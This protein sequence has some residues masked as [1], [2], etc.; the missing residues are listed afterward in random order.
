MRRLGELDVGIFHDH[1]PIAPRVEKT[2]KRTRQEAAASFFDPRPHAR[3]VV[4][5]EA[6]MTAAILMRRRDFH[7]V[8]ELIAELDE[9][10]AWPLP[11]QREVEDATVEFESR[12]DIADFEGDVIDA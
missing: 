8:D 6:E 7:E 3:S 4:D 12:V 5:D 9:G 11:A 2:E 10:V 1:D